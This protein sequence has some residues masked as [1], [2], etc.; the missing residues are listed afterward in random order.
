MMH[1]SVLKS[2][3]DGIVEKLKITC[4]LISHDPIDALSW[5]DEILVMKDG[6]IVRTGSPQ[7]IYTRPESEYVAGLFGS[8]NLL[9]PQ[10]ANA[11]APLPVANTSTKNIVI[12]PESFKI[13]TDESKGVIGVVNKVNYYGSYYEAEISVLNKTIVVR[14]AEIEV[15][16][17][18]TVYVS[19]DPNDMS[20]V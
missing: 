18:N 2:V 16:T 12:R 8:Y 9:T 6:E 4:I 20:F 10:Q 3:I 13:E 17:G 11:F 5:A 19:V 1:K 14:T 15:K 7:E